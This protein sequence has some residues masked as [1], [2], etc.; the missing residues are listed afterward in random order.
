[1]KKL[2]ALMVTLACLFTAN[3]L[4]ACNKA[5]TPSTSVTPSLPSVAPVPVAEVLEKTDTTLVISINEVSG[6]TTLLSVMKTL[7]EA[8]AITYETDATNM[9]LS[10]NGKTPD[11]GSYWMLYTSDEEMANTSWGTIAYNGQTY[12]SAI[13]GAESLPV[14]SNAIYVW[15]I[16]SFS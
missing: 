16:L 4:T 7:K 14:A 5:P 2:F 9:I 13:L 12:G 1:M 10:I 15:K 8:G 11:T 3:A 6:E